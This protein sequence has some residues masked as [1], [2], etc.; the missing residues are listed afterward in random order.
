MDVETVDQEYQQLQ[1]ESQQLTQAIQ[2]FAGKLQT[3]GDSGNDQA[4]EWILDLK[5]IALQIQQEQL[6]VQ[7]LLQ[8]LHGFAVNTM[9]QAPPAQ[10]AAPVQAAAPQAQ[11]GGMLSRFMGGG[12]GQAMTT[13]VGMGAGFGIADSMI[14]SIFGN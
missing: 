3:A 1:Q 5:G 6:Q 11:G 13:G 4:K 7:A 9:Q 2:G 8:A 10:A 14:N 12:F